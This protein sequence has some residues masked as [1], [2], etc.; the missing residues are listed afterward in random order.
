M[1]KKLFVTFSQNTFLAII[2]TLLASVTHAK[3][4]APPTQLPSQMA[5]VDYEKLLYEW[6]MR[7]D[8]KKLEWT[9]DQSVRDTGLFLQQTDYGTHG[10]V[11]IFYSPEVIE[12]L[13]NDRKTTLPD[14]AIIIKEMYTPPAVIYQE[15]KGT[16][17]YDTE[18]KYEKMLERVLTSWVVMVKD[19]QLSSDGWFWGSVEIKQ[20]DSTIEQTINA[21]E[22]D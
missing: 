18:Q 6:I 12:W 20:A 16:P 4:H 17:N 1:C 13:K 9:F 3:N 21:Y 19:Q 10:S 22:V 14:G 7:F 2:V 11:R 5:L 15:L 8:Y